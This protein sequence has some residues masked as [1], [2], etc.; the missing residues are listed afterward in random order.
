M[1]AHRV[2]DDHVRAYV[3]QHIGEFHNKRL[4]RLEGMKLKDLLRRKNP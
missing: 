2:T 1:S 4:G 3:E